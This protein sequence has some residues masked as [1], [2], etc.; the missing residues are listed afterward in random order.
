MELLMVKRVAIVLVAGV[1]L[2]AGGICFGQEKPA[3]PAARDASPRKTEMYNLDNGLAMKGYDPVSYFPE[4]GGKPVEGVSAHEVTHQGVKYRFATKGNAERFRADPARYE[5]AYGGWCASAMS[6][7]G[8]RVE[9]NPEAYVVE[10]GRL[11]LFYMVG[12]ND[13]RTMWNEDSTKHRAQADG[14]WEKM[15]GERGAARDVSQFNLPA[16]KLAIG[17]Y[18]PVSYFSEGGGKPAKG[19]ERFTE[20]Y[21]GVTY[22]FASSENRE[23]FRADPAKFEPAYGGWC[24]T[25]MA[26]GKKVE[27][28]PKSFKVTNGRLFL[29]YTD[30]ITDARKKWV[31]NENALV[32]KADEAWRTM[33]DA[34]AKK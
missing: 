6:Y 32:V 1:T 25:A 4:G 11:Y 27:I 18:D 31:K 33:L 16:S 14:N 7:A 29:F 2:A 12:K 13:A 9:V 20:V 28:D 3:E 26:E 10:G 34:P 19:Q 17:G 8:K 22:R 30:F 23:R 21:R 24:A 15:S 5:P